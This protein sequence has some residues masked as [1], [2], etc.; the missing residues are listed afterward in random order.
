MLQASLAQ[1]VEEQPVSFDDQVG[2]SVSLEIQVTIETAVPER[3][4]EVGLAFP[5]IIR[6]QFLE[7]DECRQQLDRRRRIASNVIVNRKKW[8]ILRRVLDEGTEATGRHSMRSEDAH[9]GVRQGVVC[10][11]RRHERQQRN[12]CQ[13][14]K[15][16]KPCRNRMQD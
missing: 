6:L 3:T 16:A 10:R 4:T 14:E 1:L 15:P 13:R 2:V 8:S 5:L 9:D 7:C 11:T 12:H